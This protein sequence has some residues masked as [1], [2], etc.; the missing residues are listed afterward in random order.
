MQI[1]LAREATQFGRLRN[2]TSTRKRGEV[3]RSYTDTA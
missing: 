1:S 2:P 3:K